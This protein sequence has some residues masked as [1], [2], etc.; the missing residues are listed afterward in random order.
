MPSPTA[1]SWVKFF[2]NADIPSQAAATYAH[3]FVENRIQMDML[4]DL[5]KEYL[6]EMG[7]TT[8]GDIIAIL[9]HAKKVYEQ[10]AREKVLSIP[11]SDTTVPIATVSGTPNTV[12]L[13][14]GKKAEK[15]LTT[16]IVSS[17]GTALHDVKPRR[18]LPEHEGK[19]KITL[20]SGSTARSKEILEKKV[21]L[22]K[23]RPSVDDQMDASAKRAATKRSIFDRLTTEDEPPSKTA[24]SVKILDSMGSPTSSSIFSRL[25]GRNSAEQRGSS[26]VATLGTSGI[27][28]KSPSFASSTSQSRSVERKVPPV[29][30]K[31]ILVKRIPAKAATLSSDED[32]D[33]EDRRL[34]LSSGDMTGGVKSVSFSEEDEVLEIAPRKSRKPIVANSASTSRLRFNERDV[35]VKQ[36]L[37]AGRLSATGSGSAA[38]RGGTGAL[39]GTRKVVQMKPSPVKLSPARPSM[40]A[41]NM[42]QGRKQPIQNRLSLGSRTGTDSKQLWQRLERFSLDSKLTKPGKGNSSTSN[43][44]SVFNRLGYNRK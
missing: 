42:A 1:A 19:Y 12:T 34:D 6:R 15:T 44:G 4:M 25:G 43:G 5:N 32:D 37:G 11:D 30:Q 33:D 17:V 23:R 20:P 31:V 9:R 39:H 22:T 16:R 8:M 3:V 29:V 41:D 26:D 27:L 36:R 24:N 7:I 10:S 28:K 18:V 14:N 35:P 40:K 2:T 13:S 38:H 21:Q